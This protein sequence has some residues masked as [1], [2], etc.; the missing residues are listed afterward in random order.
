MAPPVDYKWGFVRL[1]TKAQEQKRQGTRWHGIDGVVLAGQIEGMVKSSII[2]TAVP[3]V[4]LVCLPH[5]QGLPLPG[6]ETAGAAGLDLRAALPDDRQIILLP[7]KRILVPTGLIFEIP[8]GFEGQVRPRSGLALKHGITC[9]NTPGTIDS[10]YRGEV[11]VLLINHGEEDFAITRGMRIAQLVIAP[12]IQARIEE[13]VQ[14]AE[15]SR[16]VGGFGSTGTE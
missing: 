13:R 6:Y 15:T 2:P 10:D 7:G 12:V 11:Q 9:L 16:G 4:G 14:L 1:A 3:T 8:A 5:F